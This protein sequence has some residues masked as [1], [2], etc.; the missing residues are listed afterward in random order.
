MIALSQIS[1]NRL[2]L[3]FQAI[4]RHIGGIGNV[5]KMEWMFCEGNGRELNERLGVEH[6]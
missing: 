6:D 2:L 3:K 1:V 5:E 4:W